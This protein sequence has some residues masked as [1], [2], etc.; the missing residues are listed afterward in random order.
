MC[1]QMVRLETPETE[2]FGHH[3]RYRLAAGYHQPGWRVLDAACGSGYGARYFDPLDYLGVDQ[4]SIER[5][6]AW[7]A[8]LNVWQIPVTVDMTVS[9]ETI[10]H[11]DDP[12][13]FVAEICRATRHLI[14]ASVPVVP[15]VG[16]NP[17]HKVDFEPG[18][19]PTWPEWERYGWQLKA[20]LGQPDELSEIYVW[21]ATS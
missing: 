19:L 16:V 3:L 14:I 7:V 12:H 6:N 2:A 18:E 1:E 20:T 13:H 11:L 4:V 17:Y 10:E 21:K 8:D 9:F 15:T 5:S